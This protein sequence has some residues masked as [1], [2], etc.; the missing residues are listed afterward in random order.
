MSLSFFWWKL[1]SQRDSRFEKFSQRKL[2][3]SK[4]IWFD[5]ETQNVNNFLHLCELKSEEQE[6]LIQ[7]IN[8]NQIKIFD[9]N[10]IWMNQSHSRMQ[11]SSSVNLATNAIK[12]QL[13]DNKTI[14]IV[15]TQKK[16]ISTIKSS[17]EQIL[18]L[19]IEKK[20]FIMELIFNLRILKVKF[21]KQISF[22]QIFSQHL[23]RFF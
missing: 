23:L 14:L 1:L 15:V 18:P 19:V 12:T 16:Y 9:P 17:L 8:D 4:K 13:S 7:A 21:Q 6:K 20:K 3:Y 22:S 11:D 5:F 2:L 10:T